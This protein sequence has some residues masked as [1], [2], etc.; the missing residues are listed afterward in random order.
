MLTNWSRLL[1]SLR[2][3]MRKDG[4]CLPE[5]PFVDSQWHICPSVETGVQKAGAYMIRRETPALA[6]YGRPGCEI[7]VWVPPASPGREHWPRSAA[8]AP[9]SRHSLFRGIQIR[10]LQVSS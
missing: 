10:A 9:Q 2:A 6:L 3:A 1:E 5:R 7:V 4:L 8:C